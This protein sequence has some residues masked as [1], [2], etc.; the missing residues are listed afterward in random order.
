MSVFRRARVLIRPLLVFAAALAGL[1]LLA[2][3]ATALSGEDM[4]V[5]ALTSWNAMGAWTALAILAMAGAIAFRREAPNVA[6]GLAAGTLLL[7]LFSNFAEVYDLSGAGAIGGGAAA[8]L[9]IT[10]AGFFALE[11]GAYLFGTI[12]YLTVFGGALMYLLSH[13][14]ATSRLAEGVSIGA[15]LAIMC[16]AYAGLICRSD[17]GVMRV[18]L[19]EHASGRQARAQ[20]LLGVVAP[21]L[22]G[23]FYLLSDQ[24]S[25][26]RAELLLL[27]ATI[28]GVNIGLIILMAVSLE[29]VDHARRKAERE[30]VNRAM[31]DGLT[32][33]F[34]REMLGRRFAQYYTQGMREQVPF[35]ALM[36][37]L[38]HFKQINDLGG[39]SL[40]D[41]VLRR[42]ARAMRAQLR[43][44]DTMA[45]VGGEEFAVILPGAGLVEA[46]EVAE[47]LRACVAGLRFEDQYGA[48][49][50]VTVSIGVAEWERG[51]ELRSLY[52]R[53][54]G[55]LYAAK[56]GGRDRVLLA[57]PTAQMRCTALTLPPLSAGRAPTAVP[58]LPARQTE[59][60]RA[61]QC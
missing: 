34:N 35:T 37:D 5:R 17:R 53:A 20:M 56:N 19:N 21:F 7:C 24:G 61:P 23:T 40:G 11:A 22:L 15:A 51:E 8:L 42:T 27:V 52:A 43:L 47:R 13:S 14:I 45:R 59:P 4:V 28:V 50:Q 31:R 46:L 16:L 39:H 57:P 10:A 55:A 32:G 41:R 1:A 33:L 25:Q 6:R 30:L 18:L 60:V 54:D 2:Q 9:G 26:V 44:E 58:T 38:D 3:M 29:R 36:V 49:L 48:A 12:A